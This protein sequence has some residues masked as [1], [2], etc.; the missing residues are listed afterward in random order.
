MIEKA[1]LYL[2]KLTH[3][4]E[5]YVKIGVTE[6]LDARMGTFRRLGFEVDLLQTTYGRRKT[7]LALEKSFLKIHSKY[8]CPHYLEFGGYTECFDCGL[9]EKLQ[10]NLP[11]QTLQGS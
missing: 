2:T 7:M 9:L 8:R 1:H 11:P 10:E 4:N 3:D 5:S 6:N